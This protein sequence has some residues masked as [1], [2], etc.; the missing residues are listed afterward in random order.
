M[1][2]AFIEIKVDDRLV[3]DALGRVLARTGN[4]KPAFEDIGEALLLSHHERWRRQVAPDGTP[5]QCRRAQ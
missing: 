4:L 2:G 5:W 3:L 1:A